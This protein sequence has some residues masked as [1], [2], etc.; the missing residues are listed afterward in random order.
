MPLV[1]STVP[2]ATLNMPHESVAVTR[3]A[4]KVPEDTLTWRRRTIRSA[5]TVTSLAKLTTGP[6]ESFAPEPWAVR[7]PATYR[8]APVKVPVKLSTVVPKVM[9]AAEAGWVSVTVP[10]LL[11]KIA[12]A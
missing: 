8:A 6:P 2:P 5:P 7:S 10:T 3:S 12:L 1:T 11:V 4:R 9:V